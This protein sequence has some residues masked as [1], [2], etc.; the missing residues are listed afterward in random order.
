MGRKLNIK[1]IIVQ[2][3][4][5]ENKAGGISVQLLSILVAHIC[6]VPWSLGLVLCRSG[7]SRLYL[8][9]ETQNAESP[10]WGS[11]LCWGYP[12]PYPTASDCHLFPSRLQRESWIRVKLSLWASFPPGTLSLKRFSSSS[13]PEQFDAKEWDEMRRARQVF[14]PGVRKKLSG[15]EKAFRAWG[16]WSGQHHGREAEHGA[17]ETKRRKEEGVCRRAP[18]AACQSPSGV[19]ED[20]LQRAVSAWCTRRSK[21]QDIWTWFL[22]RLLRLWPWQHHLISWLLYW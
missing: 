13:V 21:Q 9:W 15:T 5:L 4:R 6:R 10:F 19:N 14:V 1:Q 3:K 22:A 17:R 20:G 7:G 18:R 16:M 2:I 11:L 8:L 12:P